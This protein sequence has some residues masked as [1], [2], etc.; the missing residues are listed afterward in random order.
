MPS[1][2]AENTMSPPSIA[3]AG[4]TSSSRM[5]TMRA[6]TPSSSGPARSG[7]KAG[8]SAASPAPT[9]A[10]IASTI[11][12]ARS[13]HSSSGRLVTVTKFEARK[14]PQ[15]PSTAKSRAASGETPREGRA[16]KCALAPPG[17]SGWP[18]THLMLFGF[19]VRSACMRKP[20]SIALPRVARLRHG[21][22][23]G[24]AR[25]LH[26]EDLALDVGERA[27]EVAALAREAALALAVVAPGGERAAHAEGGGRI[28]VIHLVVDERDRGE[29]Q[30]ARALERLEVRRLGDAGLLVEH[31]PGRE[32]VVQAPGAQQLPDREAVL[33]RRDR[34]RGL[35]RAAA[36]DLGQP[37]V[38]PDQGV[39]AGGVGLRERGAHAV[40]VV[41]EAAQPL[42]VERVAEGVVGGLVLD[43]RAALERDE[44]DAV[45]LGAVAERHQREE[46]GVERVRVDV[47]ARR[48]A[49]ARERSERRRERAL[50]PPP[51]EGARGDDERLGCA[52]G[53][54]AVE[55]EGDEGRHVAAPRT[56]SST[57]APRTRSPARSAS[58][59]FAASSG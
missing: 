1:R 6:T 29:G 49:R 7:T 54:H 48:R 12:C 25:R 56:I 21:Q 14:T 22:P 20:G 18:S 30:P 8:P 28:E 39:P 59:S 24:S 26:P 36:Q 42:A 43:A 57:A 4:R 27:H 55:V 16:S 53:D 38:G 40:E 11:G 19:G 2:N 5:R 52:V 34:E 15:T 41:M 47:G 50:G 32:E 23:P 13:V 51:R 10:W 58:A 31:A 46:A 35:A 33:R 44:D 3:T 9:E 37:R 45:V 17:T